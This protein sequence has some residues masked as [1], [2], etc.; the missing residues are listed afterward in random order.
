MS[1]WNRS[2]SCLLIIGN[3]SSSWGGVRIQF[4]AP[5][6]KNFFLG[7]CSPSLVCGFK[8]CLSFLQRENWEGGGSEIQ[9]VDKM[10]SQHRCQ[11][12]KTVSTDK[13]KKFAALGCDGSG[14]WL[15]VLA[16][17][18]WLT[19]TRSPAGENP[20]SQDC[21]LWDFSF[22]FSCLVFFFLPLGAW[23]SYSTTGWRDTRNNWCVACA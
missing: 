13:W 7:C 3:I 1:N 18:L 12:W 17:V 19:F 8:V 21:L 10:E 11:E 5:Q 6:D 2:A 22:S 14:R 9:F 23:K 16:T 4:A 15:S 20:A